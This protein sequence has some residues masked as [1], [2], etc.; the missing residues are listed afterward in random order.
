MSNIDR[1]KYLYAEAGRYGSS[2][3]PLL[4]EQLE[5]IADY[6]GRLFIKE[7]LSAYKNKKTAVIEK[8]ISKTSAHPG[9]KKRDYSSEKRSGWYQPAVE[10]F[11][12]LNPMVQTTLKNMG[13]GAAMTAGG[14]AVAAPVAS[15]YVNR[16]SDNLMNKVKEYA[17]PGALAVAGLAAGAYGASG[18]D[19]GKNFMKNFMPRK[20]VAYLIQGF[21]TREKLATHFGEESSEVRDC[22]SAISRLMCRG[23]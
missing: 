12:K 5:K 10:A 4:Q 16:E 21:K 20:K 1:A 8:P 2:G 6:Y 9:L 18:T 22:E 19:S 3:N 13:R 23:Y 11:G 17:I 7:A 14:A 15:W